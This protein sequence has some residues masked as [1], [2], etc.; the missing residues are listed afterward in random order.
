MPFPSRAGRSAW[1][2]A[3]LRNDPSD[4][5][6]DPTI[7][8]STDPLTLEMT[9]SNPK[10]FSTCSFLFLLAPLFLLLAAC[11]EG[12]TVT[13]PPPELT[14]VGVVVNSVELTLTVF[15]L[16][17]PEETWTIPL[18]PEGTPVGGAVRGGRA[19]VP[20]GIVPTAVVVDL[21]QGSVVHTVALP[22]GSGATGAAFVNDSIALVANPGLNSV[23]PVNA[24]SG[25]VGAQIPVGT[26]PSGIT[27]VGDRVFVVNAELEDFSPT[28]P[29]TLTVLDRETLE[30]TG[31]VELSGKNPG[32]T[33]VHPGGFLYVVNG[34][35]WGEGNGS[36]SVVD[37]NLAVEAAHHPGFGEFPGQVARAGDGRL[38]VSSWSYG[39]VSWNPAT[40]SF[41]RGPDDPI[42]PDGVGAAPGVAVDPQGGLWSLFPDCSDPSRVLRLSQDYQVE[43][44]V[45]VGI[46]PAALYFTEIEG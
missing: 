2:F 39:L 1:K 4:T 32:G 25:T 30:V 15:P 14:T 40:Q 19:V 12:I 45:D 24:L 21:A 5:G 6:P 17:E 27:V 31:A 33:A 42:Q 37:V 29:G 18:G 7:R 35:T 3:W 11:E 38:Y 36:L 28:G 23:S 34:G 22:Q 8:A 46:C 43:V 26:Y 44:S 16:A 20:M 10:R 9:L 41:Q 13:D